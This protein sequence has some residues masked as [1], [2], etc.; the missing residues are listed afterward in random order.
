MK[1]RFCDNK[2]Q[3][4][5]CQMVEKEPIF[6]YLVSKLIQTTN[7]EELN[8]GTIFY[9]PSDPEERHTLPVDMFIGSQIHLKSE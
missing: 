1:N 3:N 2:V 9:Y 8:I 6:K 7:K 4:S 5:V